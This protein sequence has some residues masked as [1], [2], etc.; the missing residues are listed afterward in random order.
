MQKIHNR[1]G[2][3]CHI[4]I[5]HKIGITVKA[6]QIGFF[7]T[8]RNDFLQNLFI[9]IGVSVIT[10]IDISFIDILS[11]LTVVGILQQRQTA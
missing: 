1:L 7:Q 3:L 6:Q 10:T 9:I 4:F 2:I 11:Q 8:Q 5:Q